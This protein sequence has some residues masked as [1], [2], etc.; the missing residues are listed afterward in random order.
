MSQSSS[1]RQFLTLL[2][3]GA[4]A[5]TSSIKASPATAQLP[6][7]AQEVLITDVKVYVM[8]RATFVQVITNTG[9][10]GWGEGD[11]DNRRLIA[12]VIQSL[13]KPVMIGKSP[14][15]SEYLWNQIY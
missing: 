14:F 2:G 6:G 10:S 9:A 4:L 8:E 5:G 11:H 12:E 3:A 15:Q 13:C 7:L 1:R